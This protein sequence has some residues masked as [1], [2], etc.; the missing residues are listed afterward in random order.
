MTLRM[1]RGGGEAASPPGIYGPTGGNQGIRDGTAPRAVVHPGGSPVTVNPGGS[2]ASA[3]T[4]AGV[5]GTVWVTKGNYPISTSLSP[6]QNQTLVFESA[7]GYSRS[8]SDSAVLDGGNGPLNSLVLSNA[9][10]VTIRGGLWKNQGDATSQTWASAILLG[11]G[12]AAGGCVVEDAIIGP[13]YNTGL[14]YQGPNCIARRDYLVAN[15]RYGMVISNKGSDP[16]Y[17]GDVVERC[18]FDNNN[19]R[20]L[21][22]ATVTGDSGA[23]KY[24]NCTGLIF[25]TSWCHDNYGAGFWQDIHGN[26]TLV[27]DCVMEN[28]LYWGIFYEICSGGTRIRRNALY[29]NANL[30]PSS[31]WFNAVGLLLS[32]SDATTGGSNSVIEVYQ[33][34]IDESN[35]RAMGCIDHT[36]HTMLQKGAYFHDNDVWLR[37]SDT[38]RVGGF[39]NR[40]TNIYL[41]ASNNRF[42]NNHY[43]VT[44]TTLAKWHWNTVAAGV[45]KTWVQWQAYGW[46]EPGGLLE[47]I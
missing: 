23:N 27:E 47:L 12:S 10:G 17:A 35:E 15:G 36:S 40:N 25:R 29:N 6:L 38:G 3:I 42:E 11:G 37:S 45:D 43:H 9:S 21:D 44:N 30:S 4:T 2:I 46:D 32:C 39:S 34:V 31:T 14:T 22:P 1:R 24:T 33:N 19:T 8:M 26:D 5:G 20:Q 7:S 41:A 16:L 28:N 13:N 18:R